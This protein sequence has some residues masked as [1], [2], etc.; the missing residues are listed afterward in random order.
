MNKQLVID[1]H[2][3]FFALSQGDYH[4]LKPDNPPHWPDK[5]N[6]CRDYLID[7]LSLEPPL[8]L[9]GFV[10]IEAGF[11]NSKPYREIEW[12]E[13]QCFSVPFRSIAF[14]NLTLPTSKFSVQLKQLLSYSSVVGCRYILDQNAANLLTNQTVIQNLAL[15]AQHKLLFEC[16]LSLTDKLALSALENV[17]QK[18]PS[19]KI[20]I[21]HAGLIHESNNA[22]SEQ[23]KADIEDQWLIA[24]NT[25]AAYKQCAIKCSGWE[26]VQRKY[27]GIWMQEII[28]ACLYFMGEN[29]VMLASNFPLCTLSKDYQQLWN[30]YQN[31]PFS[32]PVIN[33]MTFD[34]AKQW[35][36]L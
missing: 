5:N 34:N 18:L 19:L 36:Q 28:Q 4:W 10:H 7:N 21:N 6:L 15:L 3:H 8:H 30:E 32:A 16:Q 26:M 17:M 13:Q 1:P 14:V 2:L 11:D 31:L 12:L 22:F 25:L 27:N 35:Y 29:N 23:Y 20:M 9:A 33:K 24:L